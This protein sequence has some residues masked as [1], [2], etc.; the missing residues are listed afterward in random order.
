MLQKK[1]LYVYEERIPIKLQ[2]MVIN[3]IKL[4]KFKFRKMT[5]KTPILKQKKFFRWCDAV[6]FAPGRNIDEA[7]IKEAKNCKIFQ[8]WS[9]GYEKFNWKISQ[10]YQ[11]P[12]CTNG[13]Q[14]YIAVAEHAIMLLLSLSKK[15]IHFNKITKLGKWKNN[16]HGL[17]LFE[18]KNK[19]IGIF[20]LGRI[21]L[22]FAKICKA[23]DM[24]VY[25]Y[26]LIRK[27]NSEKKFG[28]KYLNKKAILKKCEIF[29]LH[30]HLN[31]K[32]VNFLNSENLKNIKKG[33]YIIN[34]SRAQLIERN[35]LIKFLKN[36]KLGGLGL[37]THYIEPTKKNDE[38]LSLP[39]VICTPHTAGSTRDT[40][41]KIIDICIDN[42]K[43]TLLKKKCEYRVI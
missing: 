26:D 35:I 5:Y 39:N 36:G 25:Y 13:S 29:S 16:S 6:F 33:S 20:G 7:L 34:V 12:V 19:N 10:K 14:N 38:L 18:L 31:N 2:K 8:L 22:R 1:L 11:I 24:N 30:L 21:G 4:E 40:Y 17:D 41:K 23:F 43:K 28:F 27:K 37:D 15:I 9:S 3:K 32:T 42:I